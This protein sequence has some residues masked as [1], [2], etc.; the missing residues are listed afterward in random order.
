MTRSTSFS[1]SLAGHV[2]CV[3]LM[4]LTVRAGKEKPVVVEVG[5]V[6][7]FS[8]VVAA[9]SPAPRQSTPTPPARTRQSKPERQEPKPVLKEEPPKFVWRPRPKVTPKPDEPKFD[10]TPLDRV[11]KERIRPV[12]T[13]ERPSDIV[14]EGMSAHQASL[15][16]AYIESFIKRNWN[17]PSQASVGDNPPPVSVAIRVTKEGRI[18]L[19]GV[20]RRSGIRELDRSA[21]QAIER[22]GRLPRHVLSSI[23]G[24]HYDVTIVFRITDEV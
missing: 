7:L 5:R 24:R 17:R 6:R 22:S 1:I 14:S 9:P 4:L 10:Y 13:N 11:E 21:V 3:G 15:L 23:S 12:Q 18:T 2:V 8:H 19:R 16:D 20:S